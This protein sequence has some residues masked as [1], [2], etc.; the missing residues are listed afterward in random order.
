MYRTRQSDV[1]AQIACEV[2]RTSIRGPSAF[3]RSNAITVE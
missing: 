2:R 3:V 1:G